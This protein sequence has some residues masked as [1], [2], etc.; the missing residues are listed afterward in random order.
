MAAQDWKPLKE[1][2]ELSNDYFYPMVPGY[3]ELKYHRLPE[4]KKPNIIWK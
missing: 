4:R 1:A 2:M 3:P